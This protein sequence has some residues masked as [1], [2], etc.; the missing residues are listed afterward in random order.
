MKNTRPAKKKPDDMQRAE[1]REIEM[2]VE[3]WQEFEHGVRLFNSGKFWHSHEAWEEVW[4]R[5]KEDERLFFQGVIQLAAA[6]HQ[7]VTKKSYKG[8]MNNFNKAHAKL[9]VF[10]PEY[11]G[12]SVAPLLGSIRQAKE[13]A[14]RLGP[15]DLEQFNY[16]LIPKLEFHKPTNPDLI[17]EIRDIVRSEE[18][19]E[20]LQLFN[21][22]YYWEAHEVWEALCRSQN[23]DGKEFAAAFSQIA[24]AYSFLKLCKLSS[25]RYLFEKAGEKF[26]QFEYLESGIDIEAVVGE[27]Q[28]ALE[29]LAE[30]P[31]TGNV[32]GRLPKPTI[33]LKPQNGHPANSRR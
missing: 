28:P 24:A 12:I 29:V 6:Y 23:G 31:A 2:S 16:D 5:H 18:F 4:K 33:K 3:D 20:G 14:E 19:N 15:Y 27:I 32:N 11:L 8:M 10:Q 22:G 1:L 30:M 26:R 7:L 13:E 21:A 9:E 25:A 17:V